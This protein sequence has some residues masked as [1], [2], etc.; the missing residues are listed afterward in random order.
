MSLKFCPFFRISPTTS[1]NWLRNATT[2]PLGQKKEIY[3][4][5]ETGVSLLKPEESHSS[6]YGYLRVFL[7]THVT[8]PW[9]AIGS[10][11][12]RKAEKREKKKLDTVRLRRYLFPVKNTTISSEVGFSD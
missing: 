10:R 2:R 6:E 3:A 9:R 12:Q 11:N 5:F 1:R 8:P 7:H 4:L